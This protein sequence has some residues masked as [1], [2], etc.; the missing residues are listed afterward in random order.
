MPVG[1][2]IALIFAITTILLF[3]WAMLV[4]AFFLAA[5]ADRAESPMEPSDRRIRT[6]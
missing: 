2:N 5:S 6:R 3:A 4:A 1:L